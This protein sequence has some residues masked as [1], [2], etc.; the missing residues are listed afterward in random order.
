MLHINLLHLFKSGIRRR[1]L[2]SRSES[3][4]FFI[5]AEQNIGKMFAVEV[6]RGA[7]F[8]TIFAIEL[9]RVRIYVKRE[10]DSHRILTKTFT[11]NQYEVVTW[12]FGGM[13]FFYKPI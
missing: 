10:Y 2:Y 13:K 9:T 1:N 5:L 7:P 6:H 12:D 4:A 3:E 8:I 11:M